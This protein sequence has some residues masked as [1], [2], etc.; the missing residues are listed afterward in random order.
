[1]TPVRTVFG[2]VAGRCR[3]D[4]LHRC[5]SRVGAPRTQRGGHSPRRDVAAT[6]QDQGTSARG[7]G[8]GTDPGRVGGIRCEIIR[9]ELGGQ[10]DQVISRPVVDEQRLHGGGPVS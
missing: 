3:D 2:G 9:P 5:D 1:M 6:E 7:G 8:G 4:C 10:P